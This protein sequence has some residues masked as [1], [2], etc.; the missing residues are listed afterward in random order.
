MK[1]SPMSVG[2][3]AGLLLSLLSATSSA[4]LHGS[5]PE[6]VWEKIY[7][8]AHGWHT[9]I[10]LPVASVPDGVWPE[11]MDFSDK[12]YVEVG[13]G[14]EGFYRSKDVSAMEALK[15]AL[16]P[17]KSVLHVAGFNSRVEEYFTQSGIV[18][19]RVSEK[20]FFE[21]LRYINDTIERRGAP[22]AYLLGPGLYGMSGFYAA[23]GQYT[24]FNNCNHWVARGFR[25]AGIDMDP[26]DSL[27]AG[28]V[29]QQAAAKGRVLRGD[30]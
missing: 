27:T 11:L 28:S 16:V 10:V 12:R 25:K 15:A 4:P 20:G 21:L 22:R 9:G 7:L 2:R 3:A 23:R 8:T 17:T 18:E 13:W 26:A 1:S 14:D 24:L 30:E 5:T 6:Q 19:F 29:F